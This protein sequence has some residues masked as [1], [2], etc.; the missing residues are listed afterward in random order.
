MRKSFNRRSL[1]LVPSLAA[2]FILLGASA[3]QAVPIY[4]LTTSNQLIRFESNNPAAL[5]LSLGVTGLAGGD[6]LIGID[7]RPANQQLYALS[8]TGNVYVINTV[9]GVATVVGTPITPALAGTEFGIDFN[10]VP[11]RLRIVS[12]AEQNLRANPNTGGAATVDGPLAYN[13]GDPNQGQNPNIVGAAY[14]NNF[15]GATTTVLYDIDS[16]LN[17]LVTQNPPN[18]GTLLTTGALGVNPSNL[19]G[20][21]IQTTNQGDTAYASFVLEGETASKLYRINLTTG[22]ATFLGAIASAS[23]V[24]DIAL[25]P[26]AFP[27]LNA[28]ALSTANSLLRFN[29]SAPQTIQQTIPITGLTVGDTVAGIDFRPATGQ[30]FAFA[31]PLLVTDPSR[32]YTINPRTGAATLVASLSTAPT[33]TSFGFD[34]NPTV[35]RI[36]IN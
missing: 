13:A 22:A 31:Q 30:L 9:T 8:N 5:T 18:N 14:T 24:R 29:T 26:A 2:L 10:P 33:G 16:T 17:I 28:Y 27:S 12:D 21:D 3:A 34:F 36:R 1:W 32:L 19:V 25:A 35:D 4:G 15:A 6:V 7:F 23:T 20:F 11:D